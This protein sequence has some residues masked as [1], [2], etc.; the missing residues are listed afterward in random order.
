MRPILNYIALLMCAS[1][2][3][4][5]CEET[6]VADMQDPRLPEYSEYGRNETGAYI[7]GLPWRSSPYLE[8]PWSTVERAHIRH[9]DST[10]ITTM[11]LPVGY[12]V[13]SGAT[14]SQNYQVSFS[15][16]FDLLQYYQQNPTL[17][18]VIHLNGIDAYG[19]LSDTPYEESFSCISNKGMLFIRFVESV[20]LNNI[21]ISGTFGFEIADECGDYRIT[22]GRFDFV[23]IS[24]R[25]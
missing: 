3:L 23:F 5:A 12:I 8:S 18:I 2:L 6:Y 17:P 24:H 7:D 13:P 20:D 10:G 1:A 19:V 22:S 11:R 14:E 16:N 15:I 25:Y 4:T 21:V 9:I